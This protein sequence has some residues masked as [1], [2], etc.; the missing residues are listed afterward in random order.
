VISRAIAEA[1]DALA[2]H[3]WTTARDTAAIVGDEDLGGSDDDRQTLARLWD[4]GAEASWWLGDLDNCIAGRERAY[5]SF[6]GLGETRAAAQCAIWLYEHYCF[7]AQPVIA[8][9]W[10]RRARLQ[11]VGDEECVEFGNLV[12][13]EAEAD[14]GGGKLDD[15]ASAA[16]A[17][18]A[19]GRRLRSPELEAQAL[20]ALGRV[21]IDQGRVRDG[22]GFLDDA[23]LFALDGHLSPYSTGKI[24]CSLISACEEVGDVERAAEWTEATTRWSERHPLALFP[25]ICRVHHAWALECRGD[26]HRAEQEAL[27]ACT[28]LA[29]ISPAAVAAGY[30]ELGEIRRRLGDLD[31][32]EEAFADAEAVSGRRQAGLALVRLA[33]ARPDVA[34]AI[35]ADALDDESWNRL[36]RAKLLPAKVQ[37]ALAVGDRDGALVAVEELETIAADFE[38]SA[39]AAMAVSARGRVSLAEGDMAGACTQLRYAVERW[40]QLDVPYEG[41]TARLLLAQAYRAAGDEDGAT[42]A[43][44]AAEATFE[45]LGARLDVQAARRLRGA[46]DTPP[47]GLTAREVEVLRLVATGR[48]NR[49]IATAL[50]L[51]EKTV[52]RHLSNIFIKID[53]STR[54]AATA[55][56]FA[57]GIASGRSPAAG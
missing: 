51:S 7:R 18:V 33:Q 47:A 29:G 37:I 2:R 10:L 55:F 28:Q 1:R 8:G 26:W 19:L 53:V 22:F 42:A 35:I 25:G 30:A 23:M 39:T 11:L 31:G 44:A 4:V 57:H 56:A 9:A 48:T 43:F 20:Q 15:A 6:D 45:A 38:S 36:A 32:A 46:A 12:L 34:A 49:E 17:V 5:A 21:L 54:A 40:R 41:A 16:G 52:A 50:F 27:R 13:R 14:H 3:D 24:Y